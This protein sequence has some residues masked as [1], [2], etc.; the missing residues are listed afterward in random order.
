MDQPDST[1]L[2]GYGGPKMTILNG[3]F[4]TVTFNHYPVPVVI[5]I[6][7]RCMPNIPPK[8]QTKISQGAFID[9]TELLQTDFH[10][11]TPLWGHRMSMEWSWRMAPLA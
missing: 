6:L 3:P 1:T 9:F 10:Y 5:V 4:S 2:G 7:A 8:L 11:N